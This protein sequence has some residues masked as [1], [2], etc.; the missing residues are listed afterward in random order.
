MEPPNTSWDELNSPLHPEAKGIPEDT[1]KIQALFNSPLGQEVLAI[2][3]KRTVRRAC[4]QQVC[5]DGQNTAIMMAFRDG[6]NN[7][8]RW[9]VSQLEKTAHE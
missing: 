1:A 3:E 2:L 7:I 6:E 9:I 4:L 5:P 8:Y